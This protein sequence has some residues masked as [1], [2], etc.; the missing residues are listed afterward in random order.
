MRASFLDASR[1]GAASG[2][3]HKRLK[4]EAFSHETFDTVE[5][6]LRIER[7]DSLVGKTADISAA[8]GF[9]ERKA[10]GYAASQ[11]RTATLFFYRGGHYHSA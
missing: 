1:D 2:R 8:R 11:K 7:L 9:C 10:G 6:Q 4:I 5:R 3:E